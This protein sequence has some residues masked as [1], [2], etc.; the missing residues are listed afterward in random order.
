M[1]VRE[2]VTRLGFDAD[3]RAARN[4][5]GAIKSVA[6]V[7]RRAAVAVGSI[8]AA[9]TA[10]V[11]QFSNASSETLAWSNRL[12]IASS[13]LQSLGFAAQ[14]YQITNE[15]LTDGLKELS[16]RT[17]EFTSTAAGP[18]QEAFERLGLT[19]EE[20][21][22]VSGNTGQLFDLVR[23][24]VADI[25][26]VAARQRIADELFGGQAGEQFSEFLQISGDELQRL[27]RLAG[28]VGAVVPR[29]V[30][31]RA[32]EFSRQS[33]TL[34]ATVLGFGKI[35][36]AELLPAYR[37]FV[38]RTQEYLTA[39]ADLIRQNIRQF[40][41]GLVFSLRILVSV[42]GDIASGISSAVDFI[43]GWRRAIS[44]LTAAL[45]TFI[46]L[47][48]AKVVAGIATALFRARTATVAL[49]GAMALLA[50]TPLIAALIALV[51]LAEDVLFWLNGQDSVIGR[52]VGSYDDLKQ[53]AS[54]AFDT[55]ARKSKPLTDQLA[56]DF[57]RLKRV[58]DELSFA[59][60]NAFTLDVPGIISNLNNVGNIML[61]WV[62]QIGR[63]L[64]FTFTAQIPGWMR[65][66]FGWGADNVPDDA[67]GDPRQRGMDA[68]REALD[69]V[70]FLQQL[71]DQSGPNALVNPPGPVPR[72][73]TDRNVNVRAD[74][75]LQVPQGTS[76]QQRAALEQQTKE[77]FDRE[78]DR[79]IMNSLWDFQVQE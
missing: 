72:G 33:N 23:G 26:D 69:N 8:S 64:L 79:V 70:R 67:R 2:L 68:G 47:N 27:E 39:N 15:A 77:L 43:G 3:T 71:A 4:Y 49:T 74:V 17:D 78:M 62:A 31:E 28:T 6:K 25:Q 45:V 65:D 56:E 48:V 50:K 21:N 73:V 19:V 35:L 38:E 61:D 24:R 12:G 34:R 42:L 54:D 7:A 51:F 44:L 36:A 59:I 58:S 60:A 16:L 30:L 52:L 11:V 76:E 10:L 9:T 55:V 32:R 22:A 5:E 40:V 57:G 46:G 13:R 1:Q 63:D 14:Q 20:L 37:E 66:L 53:S 75:S 29:D 18:A 41:E